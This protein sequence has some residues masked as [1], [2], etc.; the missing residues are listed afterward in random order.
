MF[1]KLN[2]GAKV[3]AIVLA[4]VLMTVATVSFITYSFS[5]KSLEE[6]H[7]ENL[8]AISAQKTSRVN[9]LFAKVKE[10]SVLISELQAVKEL[11]YNDTV[12]IRSPEGQTL[13][14]NAKNEIKHIQKIYGY[15]K[16]SLYN[17][18]GILLFESSAHEDSEAIDPLEEI[19]KN[20]ISKSISQLS[21]FL[22]PKAEQLSVGMPLPSKTGGIIF[23]FPAKK[24]YSILQDTLGLGMTGESILIKNLE[25]ETS[26]ISPLRL[27]DK[28]RTS[29][30][31]T[32]SYFNPEKVTS[33]FSGFSY[34]T[35]YRKNFVLSFWQPIAST[36]WSLITKIDRKEVNAGLNSLWQ[37]FLIAGALITIIAFL[38]SMVFSRFLTVPLLSLKQTVNMLGKGVLPKKVE[39]TSHDEIGEIAETVA[40]LVEGLKRTASFAHQIGEGD[41][42]ADYKPMSENDTLGNALIT[43]R[44]SI[45]EAEKQ[46]KER[47]WIVTGVAEIGEI[48]RSHNDLI[49]LGDAVAAYVTKKI[50]AIQGAFYVVN[51]EDENDTFIEMKASYA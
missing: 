50:N 25:N 39:K 48:L 2:I 30:L 43:M 33:S 4:V 46:E 42:D 16:I 37:R 1:K 8:S 18:H 19:G 28:T 5:R 12:D 20:F 13:I 6:R 10:H 51:D 44:N 49:E 40:T 29:F 36:D 3:T 32:R 35:D 22:A 23:K 41:F 27:I 47:T 21:I 11:I 26:F 34:D 38:I 45:Q 24:L 7:I 14:S 17:E 15:Q 31:G 9:D